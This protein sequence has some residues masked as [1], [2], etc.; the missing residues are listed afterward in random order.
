MA[1][2]SERIP[3]EPVFSAPSA[4]RPSRV[5]PPWRLWIRPARIGLLA[6]VAGTSALA[7][8]PVSPPSGRPV[9]TV[10]GASGA[11]RPTP[12]KPVVFDMAMLAQ[13][14]QHEIRTQSPWY[15][16]ARKFTGPLLRD[17]LKAAAVQ[18]ERIEVVALND[19]KVSIPVSDA[20]RYNVVLARLIDDEPL[21]V[22]NKGPLF[23]MY[24]FDSD[25]AL[26]NSIFYSRCAWQ[27]RALQVH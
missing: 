10:S 15:P 26:R 18:G 12:A 21:S 17:V 27:V 25:R 6:L 14:P 4:S 1:L 8:T 3:H 24:P 7:L 20:E 19:Y 23:I 2:T 13:L 22:R 5:R 9:L 11:D 16:N